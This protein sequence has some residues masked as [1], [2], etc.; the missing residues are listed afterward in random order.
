MKSSKSFWL[1]FS[2]CS[3]LLLLV[4]VPAISA[5]G[6]TVKWV[7]QVNGDDNNDGNTETTAYA[8]LQKAIDESESG[9]AAARSIIYVKDGVYGQTGQ[10]NSALC[11]GGSF[12]TAILIRDLDYLTIQ[13]VAGHEP[14][15]RPITSVAANIV[16]ISVENSNHLIIDNIDSD[17]TVAQFDNWHVCN[18]DDLTVRNSTFTGG[19]DGIDFNS[20]LATAV[21]DGNHFIDVNTGSGDEV[22]DFTDATYSDIIIQDNQ[23]VNNYRQI[24]IF[25]PSGHTATNFVIRRNVMNGT[26]SQEAVRLIGA[27][28]VTLENNVVMNSTQQ[29][30]YI[31]AGSV[32]VNVWHNTFFHNGEEELRTNVNSADIVIKNNIF[33][34]NGTHAVLAASTSPLPGED[35]NLIY[36]QGS[37]TES[38]SQPAVTTFG[39]NTITGQDPLFVSTTPGSEDL[40]LQQ[41]SPAAATGT[42]LGVTEDIEQNTRPNPPATPP[43]LGAYELGP[44]PNAQP[45]CSQAAPSSGTLWPPNHQFV[46]IDVF[47]VTDPDGDAVTITI[48]TIYQDEPVNAPGSGNTSPDGQGIG[49]STA[50]VRAERVGSGNGRVYH[51][52]F[53][54]YDGNG[55]ACSGTVL[56]GVPKSQGKKGGPIDEGPLFDSTLP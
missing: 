44:P 23:F 11:Q 7:D 20:S 2:I 55:G 28:D 8:T 38:G 32:N 4:T 34:A 35:Y 25:P 10:S 50:E 33:Y 46:A 45:D 40:H 52:T 47:G 30:L 27:T 24:T 14:V 6:P 54:A 41:G 16:S 36:N 51:I 12:A 17:Q 49:S 22:L 39:A 18:S 9:T 5:D 19:E 29:G 26:T 15:V 56:V 37:S 13:A 21:I 1:T 48:D 42:N 43:D 3:L 53:T 31:D